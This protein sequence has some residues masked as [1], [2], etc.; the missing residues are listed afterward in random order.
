MRSTVWIV[1]VVMLTLVPRAAQAW[2][3]AGHCTVAAIA[4]RQLDE[5]QRRAVGELLTHHP[6]Y[7]KFLIARKPDGVDVHEW[8]FLRSS[9]WSDWVRPSRPG[10]AEELFKGPEITS[11]HRGEWHYID[12]PWV[13]P[14]DEN[15]VDPA[16]RPAATRPAKENI[17]RAMATNA[18]ILA[19]S[20]I[21]P[22]DR[23][24]AF[25]WIMHTVGD[26]HQPLHAISMYSQEFPDG[27]RGGNEIIIRENDL[28]LRLHAYWDGALGN[29]DAYEAIEFLADGILDDPRLARGKLREMAERPAFA[30][31][32]DE[33][34]RWAGALAYLNGRLRGASSDAHYRKQITDADVPPTPHSY[35]ANTREL[36]RRRVAL[37]GY[38]LAEQISTLMPR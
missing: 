36:V 37:A 25:C 20:S 4:W 34:Y 1:F 5:A 2:N 9:V 18:K 23:A 19:D 27:D 24:V 31:W 14:Q 7:E 33:S 21:P 13:V 8:A 10:T 30:Q 16:T 28:V 35:Y 38:R 29:S 17:L 26:V 15:K 32:A 11:F 3:E 12:T 22:A 6:H